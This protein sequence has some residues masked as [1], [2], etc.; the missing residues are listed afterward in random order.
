LCKINRDDDA[1][2]ISALGDI[3]C[4]AWT[5][6]EQPRLPGWSKAI[7]WGPETV[8]AKN[9]GNTAPASVC[10]IPEA[11]YS[12]SHSSLSVAQPK[13]ATLFSETTEFWVHLTPNSA[14]KQAGDLTPQ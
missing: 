6:R 3:F 9:L 7:G 5:K 4:P 13:E 12:R 10:E 1:S 8:T 2:T 14:A 11:P